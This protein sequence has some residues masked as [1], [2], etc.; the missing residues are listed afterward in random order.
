MEKITMEVA[1]IYFISFAG[2]TQLVVRFKDEDV[3]NYNFF[4]HVHYWNGYEQYKGEGYCVKHG[5]TEI[6]EATKAE[7]YTLFRFEVKDLP[8]K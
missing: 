6:R 1:K 2:N 4:S 8:I 5:I 7:Q 3:C